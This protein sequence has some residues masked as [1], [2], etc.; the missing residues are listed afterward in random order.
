[1]KPIVLDFI[2]AIVFFFINEKENNNKFSGPSYIPSETFSTTLLETLQIPKI[3]H[4]FTESKLF[5]FKK[6]LFYEI[7]QLLLIDGVADGQKKAKKVLPAD[8]KEGWDDF[9]NTI[10][11][12]FEDFKDKEVDLDKTIT[13]MGNSLNN[14]IAKEK[15]PV[16]K[17]SSFVNLFKDEEIKLTILKI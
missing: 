1:M 14:Y 13:R 15:L 12:I 9:N 4:K 17:F 8:C 3:S 2:N 16:H 11:G 5:E 7:Y 6:N 10:N